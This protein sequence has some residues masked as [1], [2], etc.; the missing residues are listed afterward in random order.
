MTVF[1][2]LLRY[3]YFVLLPLEY[4]FEILLLN[5]HL[6]KYTECPFERVRE[7]KSIKI[8]PMWSFIVNTIQLNV[9]RKR[10]HCKFL[11]VYLNR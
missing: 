5:P 6:G 1:Y 2:L 7:E 11:M 4:D 9:Y 3:T 10:N 8:Q